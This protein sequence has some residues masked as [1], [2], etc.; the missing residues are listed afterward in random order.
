MIARELSPNCTSRDNPLTFPLQAK[1]YVVKLKELQKLVA[2]VAL[3]AAELEARPKVRF[4]IH[5]QY[6]FY[7]IHIT[8]Y[9]YIHIQYRF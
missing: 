3:R 1:L 5:I 6:I 4:R 7:T 9:L 8:Y 2:P